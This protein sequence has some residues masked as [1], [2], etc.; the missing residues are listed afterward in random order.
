MAMGVGPVQ[1]RLDRLGRV[2]DIDHRI[3][4]QVQGFCGRLPYIVQA[5]LPPHRAR[6]F[7]LYHKYPLK[8]CCPFRTLSPYSDFYLLFF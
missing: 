5:R 8:I 1:C 3:V 7:K 4:F 2:D 6:N